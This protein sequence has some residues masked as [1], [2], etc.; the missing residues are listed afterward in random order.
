MIELES[1]II[2]FKLAARIMIEVVGD[3]PDTES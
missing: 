3:S 2:G 1:F